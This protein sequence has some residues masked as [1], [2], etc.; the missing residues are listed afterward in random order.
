[1]SV[2]CCC[3]LSSHLVHVGRGPV[4]IILALDPVAV[5]VVAHVAE[6][7]GREGEELPVGLELVQQP[8]T[9]HVRIVLPASDR[10]I[11]VYPPLRWPCSFL[12]KI[13]AICHRDQSQPHVQP[14]PLGWCL[15]VRAIPVWRLEFESVDRA[16]CSSPQ[17]SLNSMRNIHLEILLRVAVHVIGAAKIGPKIWLENNVET[18]KEFEPRRF[19][20]FVDC[21]RLK[22]SKHRIRMKTVVKTI[23]KVRDAT[24]QQVDLTTLLQ[25][26]PFSVWARL[27]RPY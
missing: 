9:L 4:L 8:L 12:S 23:A 10:P 15:D 13:P 22:I 3:R 2:L 18:W 20:F 26:T 27:I 16:S 25:F 6:D 11:T 7:L 5:D 1:M 19:K 17:Y 14:P 21:S 24:I